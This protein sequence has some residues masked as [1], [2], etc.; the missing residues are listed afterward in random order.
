MYALFLRDFNETWIFFDIFS[1]NTEISN[2]MK[3]RPM[4]AKLF[5]ADGE[6]D[7]QTDRRDE[8]N[9]HFSQF[10]ERASKFIIT[11]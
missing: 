1:K 6:M 3:I 11:W 10:S 9:S 2:F 8:L 7:G 5:L 4:A